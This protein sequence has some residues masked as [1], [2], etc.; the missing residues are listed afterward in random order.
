MLHNFPKLAKAAVIT[1]SSA[2]GDT[3]GDSVGDGASL[4]A[5]AGLQLSPQ[6]AQPTPKRARTGTLSQCQPTSL[7]DNTSACQGQVA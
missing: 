4:A 2:A 6:E 5:L 7:S 3:A 1:V